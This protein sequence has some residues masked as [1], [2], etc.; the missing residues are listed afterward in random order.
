VSTATQ[1]GGMVVELVRTR[2]EW[3]EFLDLPWR[4]Y[5]ADP[6][7]VP[8]LRVAEQRLLDPHVNPFFR[9]A[10]LTAWLVRRNGTAVGRIA[11]VVDQIHN[12]IHNEE[13]GFF[14]FFEAADGDAAECLLGTVRDWARQRGLTV[15]RGPFNPSIN[16]ECGLLVDGFD[17]SPR[18]MMTYNPPSYAEYLEHFGLRKARDLYAYWFDVAAGLPEKAH[19]VAERARQTPG[20][21]VRGLDLRRLKEEVGRARQVF[22]QAWAKNWG[23]VPLTDEEWD[24][25]ATEFRP[26]LHPDLVLL[27]EIENKPVGFLLALPDIYPV[28]QGLKRWWWPWV[29]LQLGLGWWRVPTLRIALLGLTPDHQ[30]LGLAAVLYEEIFRR[31]TALGYRGGEFSWILEDN[32]MANRACVAMGGRRYKTYRIY[33]MSVAEQR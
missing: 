28:L 17:A 11:G 26:L 16:H 24:F 9:H 18:I 3:A 12:R 2:S 31:G 5:R 23:F 22:D 14:G 30:S 21:T 20:L 6:H 10:E 33:E 29:Y 27:A 13:A 7:W 8:P 1:H 15:L 19:R 4:L 32:Q 25:M